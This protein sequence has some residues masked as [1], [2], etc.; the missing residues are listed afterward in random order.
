MMRMKKQ[1]TYAVLALIA[2]IVAVFTMEPSIYTSIAL[3]VYLI[4]EFLHVQAYV[5]AEREKA[6]KKALAEKEAEDEDED[7]LLAMEVTMMKEGR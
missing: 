2:W 7:R 6:V 1:L 4:L 5:K 3:T